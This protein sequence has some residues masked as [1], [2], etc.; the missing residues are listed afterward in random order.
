[1]RLSADHNSDKNALNS[2]QGSKQVARAVPRVLNGN[3]PLSE[4]Q[5][6]PELA[7]I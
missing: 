7:I 6:G 5:L 4:W 1:M 3:M 2:T